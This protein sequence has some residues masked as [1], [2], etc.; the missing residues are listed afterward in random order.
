MKLIVLYK[1]RMQNTSSCAILSIHP[2]HP[3]ISSSI[4]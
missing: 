1:D 4:A 2:T 3:I